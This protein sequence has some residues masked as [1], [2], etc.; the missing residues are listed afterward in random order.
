MLI[1]AITSEILIVAIMLSTGSD[2]SWFCHVSGVSCL[3]HEVVCHVILIN[4]VCHVSRTKVPRGSL[5][6]VSVMSRS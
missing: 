4:V 6:N 3:A 5:V 2:V 1:V